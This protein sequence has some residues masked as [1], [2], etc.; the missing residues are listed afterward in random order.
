MVA[1]F[2]DAQATA[3]ARNA[4]VVF[5]LRE[6]AGLLQGVAHE[7]V[8]R[9]TGSDRMDLFA[10]RRFAMRSE[11]RFPKSTAALMIVI[12]AAVITT[13]EKA[14]AVAMSLPQVNPQVPPIQPVRLIL[15]RPFVLWF[16]AVYVLAALVW[17]VLFFLHRS[18]WHRLAELD[19]QSR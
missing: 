18:G 15:L 7:W 14:I 5:C 9:L 16:A 12:L 3:R 4:G 13:I 6:I 19:T 8:C 17:A 1:V 11:F 10:S 2:R